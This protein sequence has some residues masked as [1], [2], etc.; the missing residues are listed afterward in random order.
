MSFFKSPEKIVEKILEDISSFSDKK[1]IGQSYLVSGLLKGL[2]HKPT[3]SYL[4]KI[5]SKDY[6]NKAK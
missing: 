4:E 6:P 3:L 2:G 5:I 1:Q